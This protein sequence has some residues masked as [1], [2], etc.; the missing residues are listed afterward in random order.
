MS[1]PQQVAVAR[2]PGPGVRRVVTGHNAE[3]KAVVLT[4]ALI[5]PR[6][7]M[8]RGPNFWTDLFWTEDA[9]AHNDVSWSNTIS[10]HSHEFVDRKGSSFRAIEFP[11]GVTSVSDR[12]EFI[13][14]SLRGTHG[15]KLVEIPSHH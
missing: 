4:D 15:H 5:E 9:P 1:S 10:E 2:P 3:G 14:I 13:S 11:P 7:I 6:L 8:D 12:L